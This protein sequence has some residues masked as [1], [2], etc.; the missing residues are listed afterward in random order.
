M[1]ILEIA[2]LGLLI[3]TTG[4]AAWWRQLVVSREDLLEVTRRKPVTDYEEQCAQ[5]A[6]AFMME[7]PLEDPLQVLQA[8]NGQ[9]GLHPCDPPLLSK[10]QGGDGVAT[11]SIEVPM[12]E[13]GVFHALV[14]PSSFYGPAS[15]N[16]VFRE[17]EAQCQI[18]RKPSGHLYMPSPGPECRSERSSSTCSTSSTISLSRAVSSNHEAA[19]MS[20]EAGVQKPA[21]ETPAD[22]FKK[23]K[24]VPFTAVCGR[25][26]YAAHH[27]RLAKDEFPFVKDRSA[28]NEAMVSRFIR[29]SM[30]ANDLRRDHVCLHLPM[31]IAM[32]WLPNGAERL[33]AAI[34]GTATYAA[35][36]DGVRN[37]GHYRT[38]PSW[39]TRYFGLNRSGL[40]AWCLGTS[41]VWVPAPAPTPH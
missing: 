36:R 22:L 40:L 26:R 27:A 1:P 34:E 38:V 35:A 13:G 33:Q 2:A 10:L 6:E 11:H 21:E 37:R 9:S 7:D 41:Q 15:A 29:D 20:A 19:F 28:A 18:W 16:P 17:P 5:L 23:G 14:N 32:F 25:G 24:R 12:P 31:A 8:A 39:A 3:S 4:W 30:R